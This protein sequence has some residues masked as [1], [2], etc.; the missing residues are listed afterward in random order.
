MFL[1]DTNVVSE[2]RKAGKNRADATVIAWAASIP[3]VDL[4]I[5]AITVHE[6]ELGVLLAERA[7]PAKGAELRS[8]F[9]R[10]LVPAFAGRTVPVDTAVARAAAAY[11]VPNPAP[12]RDAFIGAT[13]Q[14]HDLTVATRN[15]RDFV[16]FGVP[17]VNPWTA[18]PQ[19][20]V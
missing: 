2:L 10:K 8:W 20:R 6:I 1:L 12:I 3:A 11:H 9:D 19:S 16:R 4:F 7:D 5:S 17:I 18:P 13:A 14:C 15:V